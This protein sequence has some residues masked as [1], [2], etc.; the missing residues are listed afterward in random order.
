MSLSFETSTLPNRRKQH[1]AR[2]V[3][4]GARALGAAVPN[5]EVTSR[6]GEAASVGL[7]SA[8][9]NQLVVIHRRRFGW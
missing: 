6:S 9:F 3:L 5:V 4:D 8:R 1:P 7:E 2:G